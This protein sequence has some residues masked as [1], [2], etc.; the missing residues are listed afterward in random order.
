MR[1]VLQLALLA[2]VLL[3]LLPTAWVRNGACGCCFCPAQLSTQGQPD[4]GAVVR[5]ARR[6]LGTWRGWCGG[7][8][9]LTALF[10][11]LASRRVPGRRGVREDP[12]G[13]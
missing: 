2:S 7:G 3:L 12:R 9:L 5:E 13:K 6:G 8:G 10:L 11:L 1:C 4:N